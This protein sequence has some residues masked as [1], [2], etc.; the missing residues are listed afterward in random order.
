MW[1]DLDDAELHQL[2]RRE[3]GDLDA[4]MDFLFDDSSGNV[5]RTSPGHGGVASPRGGVVDRAEVLDLARRVADQQSTLRLLLAAG[6]GA[7]AALS[8]RS[9]INKDQADELKAQARERM[10]VGNLAGARG[11][12]EKALRLH[13]HDAEGHAMAELVSLQQQ[14]EAARRGTARAASPEE[15]GGEE[16]TATP[17]RAYLVRRRPNPSFD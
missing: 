17:R 8:P 7:D 3:G 14:L 12:L 2:L 4:A 9:K 10:A 13:E 5:Q 1:A 11:A 15:E 6:G 16:R